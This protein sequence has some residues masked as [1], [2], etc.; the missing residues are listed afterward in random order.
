MICGACL[1][2]VQ[3]ALAAEIQPGFYFGLSG[4]KSSFDMEKGELDGI[5]ISSLLSERLL[6]TSRTS[7]F[8]DSDTTLSLVGGY[9]FS[10]Y[11]AVEAGY[12]DLGAAEYRSRGIVNLLGTPLTAPAAVNIDVESKG[13]TLAGLGRLP[14]GSVADLHGRLG[15][16]FGKTDLT[17]ALQIDTDGSS[18]TQ[19]LDS[20]GAF[21]A[22]GAGL[23]FGEHWSVSLDWTR[24]DN[25]GDEDEDDDA[26]TEAGFDIDNVSLSAAFR[27]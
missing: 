8:E 21:Y 23:N 20:I 24:Y 15:L 10:P 17:V 14:L 16:L 18:N 22:V 11:L 26:S 2:A 27:F 19:T 7:S 9:N 13:F 25:V 5:V 3:P 6:L 4:G 1:A 12:I